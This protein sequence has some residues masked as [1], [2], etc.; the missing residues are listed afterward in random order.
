MS[1]Y[2]RLLGF[3]QPISHY[4]IPY[5]LLMVLATLF[6]TLNLALLAPL[7]TALFSEPGVEELSEPSTWT[8]L[9]GWFEYLTLWV[10][11]ELGPN[12]ALQWI[13]VAILCSVFF[14]NLFKYGSFRVMENFRIHTLLNLRRSI[15][16]R[17]LDKDLAYFNEQRKGQIISKIAS[18]V[19]VVQYSVTSTLQVVIKEPIQLIF[20][21]LVLFSISV[22]LTLFSTLVIPISAWIISK[23]VQKL[24]SQAKEAQERFGMMIS[25][26]D[27]SLT[28]IR[29]I[30]AFNASERIKEKFHHENIQYSNLGRKMA[31]RQQLASPVSEFLGVAMVSILVLYGGNLVMSGQDTLSASGFI[32]YIAIFS[33][34]MRPAK[35][36]SEAFSQLHTG[37]A[38]GERVLEILDEKDPFQESK[39][40]ISILNFREGIK[41]NQ[42]SFAYEKK[43]VLRD[44]SLYIPK[45]KT[46]ALVGPSGGGKSTLMDMIPRFI[47]P[48]LGNITL[49]GIDL[50]SINAHSLR[51]MIGM[52]N[53][54][55]ILFHDSI[56]NNI[57]FGKPDAT[58][59][60]IE[61]AAQIANAH[62]F[63][64]NT[65]GGY[66]TVI[67]D[68][69]AKLSGGQKQR[70]CIAR[71]ILQNPPILLLDEATS[72]LDT[73]SEHLVQDAL[74][75][76]MKNRTTLV[77]A[78]RL[79]T[80][81]KADQIL[82]IENGEIKEEG[83][84]FELL[85]KEGIYSRL[86]DKQSFEQA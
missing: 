74:Q 68:R 71:A 35:A 60:E 52:V 70:I 26:L 15:F 58:Q 86:I 85:F 54:E 57:A 84:H 48:T 38:A 29:I 8:D 42:V 36:L 16:N 45:G 39:E 49:D 5:L 25:Y 50:N 34:V 53:Q 81:Q 59:E 80:I 24:R 41:F 56:R 37:L 10:Q 32:T 51:S 78:H 7:L 3:A 27:E 66:E 40:S 64:L 79:S 22:K 73:E 65:S 76:L 4:A 82:V 9:M 69:G 67:G 1:T 77:I 21:L 2:F 19:Q 46:I 12:T 47:R 28:G 13:C 43:R 44:I 61:K 6:G 72:A 18:D 30:K 17:V 23:I 31:Y 33:Q 75:Q 20:Y 11:K 14:S 83:T 63:I 55:T 62:E